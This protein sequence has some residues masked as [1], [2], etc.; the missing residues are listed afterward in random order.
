MDHPTHENH[1]KIG[2][3]WIKVI[4]QYKKPQYKME[5]N[6]LPVIGLSNYYFASLLLVSYV[7][8]VSEKYILQ[9]YDLLFHF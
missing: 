5:N 7:H 9:T 3:P 4:S 8:F 2:T 6:L 1:K